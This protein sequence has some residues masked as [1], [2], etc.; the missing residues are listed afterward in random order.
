MVVLSKEVSWSDFQ[1]IIVNTELIIAS[2]RARQ[3]QEDQL[4]E[5]V[6]I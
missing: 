2:S 5:I 4:G 3:K 1:N 6:I